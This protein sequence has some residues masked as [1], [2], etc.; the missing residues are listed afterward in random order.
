LLESEAAVGKSFNVTFWTGVA[1]VCGS[2]S[3]AGA[4]IIYDAASNF[5]G[6]QGGSTGLWQYGQLTAVGGTFTQGV[7]SGGAFSTSSGAVV[8]ASYMHSGGYF[9]GVFANL[10]FTAPT[11]GT[12]VATFQAK[13]TD[14][15]NNPYVV[16]GFP[17]YRRDGVRMWLNASFSDLQTWDQATSAQSFQFRTVT[18]TLVLSAGQSIDFSIDPNGARGFEYGA[19]PSYLGYYIY[20]STAYTATVELIPSPGAFCLAGAGGLI[21]RRRRPGI[22]G[23]VKLEA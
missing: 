3:Q 13:L 10:R 21:A 5:S 18:T 9:N 2:A 15:G 23:D 20:D 11:A 16:S 8:G 12:Y 19:Q 22:G 17:D 4:G 14:P 7:L 6:T 1:C